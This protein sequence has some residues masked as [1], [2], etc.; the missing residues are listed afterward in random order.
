LTCPR[1]GEAFPV[2][3]SEN[4][5]PALTEFATAGAAAARETLTAVR[6]TGR[7]SNRTIAGAVLGVMAG[8]AIAALVFA[9]TT[10]QRRRANDPKTPLGYLPAD[11]NIVAGVLVPEALKEPT[12]QEFLTQFRLGP[13]DLNIGNLERWTGLRRDE[14]RQ[15]VI[16]LKIEGS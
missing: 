3:L 4:G 16:G 12:G 10:V 2:R 13:I 6:S 14:I 9:L 7:W 8:V 11:T 1:C 5:Q 15:I